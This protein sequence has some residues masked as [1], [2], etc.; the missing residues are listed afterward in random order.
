MRKVEP[1]K[2][3]LAVVELKNERSLLHLACDHMRL[4]F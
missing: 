3:R 1:L 4:L 2:S